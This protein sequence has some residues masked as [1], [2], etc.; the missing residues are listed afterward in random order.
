MNDV[1]ISYARPDRE[2]AHRLADTL[3]AHGLSVWWD[4]DLA[5]GQKFASVISQELATARC[6]LVLWSRASVASN[7]VSDEASEGLQRG[8]LVPAVIEAGVQPPLGFR[9]L[10]TAELSAWLTGGSDSEL[11]RLCQAVQA[12]ARP[13][14]APGPPPHPPAPPPPPPAPPTPPPPPP[15]P[16]PPPAQPE[17]QKKSQLKRN[18]GI[19]LAVLLVGVLYQAWEQG[20]LNLDGGEGMS[21]SAA[22]LQTPLDWQDDVLHYRGRI[23][24]DGQSSNAALSAAITDMPSGRPLGI[25]E[26]QAEVTRLGPQRVKF[27]ASF[28][29]A[30][31]SKS[32]FPHSHNVTL[33]FHFGPSGWVLVRN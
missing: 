4:H 30:W 24:W 33:L 23:A 12:L 18:L 6:V 21:Q 17:P 32:N 9:G 1:F 8:V 15:P 7:W 26:V 3:E 22:P 20:D 29:L 25:Y 14:P 28:D 19:G 10:H 2:T 27:N 16:Q 5:P 13:G 11:Q 31:D